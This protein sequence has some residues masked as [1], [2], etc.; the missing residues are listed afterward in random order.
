MDIINGFW[1]R[2]FYWTQTSVR[3]VEDTQIGEFRHDVVY[4][5]SENGIIV[6]VNMASLVSNLNDPNFDMGFVNLT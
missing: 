1:Q 2:N 3:G 4:S 6:V 5:E